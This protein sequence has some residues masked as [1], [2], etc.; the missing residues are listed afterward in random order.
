MDEM[1]IQQ[2]AQ[3]VGGGY[4]LVLGAWTSPETYRTVHAAR[5]AARRIA[6]EEAAARAARGAWED[7]ATGQWI[8]TP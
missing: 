8:V 6:A 5:A 7:H 1:M 2:Q 4:K 3:R